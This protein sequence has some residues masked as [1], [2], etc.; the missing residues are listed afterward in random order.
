[1][2][3]HLSHL[4]Y[5]SKR[6]SRDPDTLMNILEVAR[7]NNEILGITGILFV[8]KNHY[9]QLMEGPRDILSDRLRLIINDDRHSDLVL[10]L[11]EELNFRMFSDWKMAMVNDDNLEIDRIYKSYS[12]EISSPHGLSGAVIWEMVEKMANKTLR[13]AY[14]EEQL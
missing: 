11:F 14:E 9:F 6:K 1:M 8:Q 2:E 13:N 3:Q 7:R 12:A 5:F 4:V 10:T